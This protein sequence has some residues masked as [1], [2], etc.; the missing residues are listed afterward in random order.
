[1]NLSIIAPAT[2]DYPMT[3]K[4]DKYVVYDKRAIGGAVTEDEQASQ[5]TNVLYRY[6]RLKKEYFYQLFQ[7]VYYICLFFGLETIFTFY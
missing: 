3:V 4:D 2:V 5:Y 7:T 6:E 1:M